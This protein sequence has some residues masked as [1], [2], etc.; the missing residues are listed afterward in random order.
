MTRQRV[1]LLE[2]DGTLAEAL[3]DL[4]ED[5]GLDVTVCGSLLELQLAVEQNPLAVVVADSWTTSDGRVLTPEHRA[6]ILAL[7]LTAGGG[8]V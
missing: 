4:F 2:D 6:E 1:L 8:E 7:A 3:C 5:D